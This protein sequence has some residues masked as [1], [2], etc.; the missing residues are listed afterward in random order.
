MLIP[1]YRDK[2]MP[3]TKII[4]NT[5]SKRT[6]TNIVTKI[7]SIESLFSLFEDEQRMQGTIN[8]EPISTP[9]KSRL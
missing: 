1:L 5:S 9:E 8:Y 4:T 6:F 2:E 7:T 3:F